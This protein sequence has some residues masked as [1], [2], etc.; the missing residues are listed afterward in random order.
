MLETG[1]ADGTHS[2]DVAGCM[3]QPHHGT[4]TYPTFPEN[5]TEDPGNT[6]ISTTRDSGEGDRHLQGA[7]SY[8]PAPRED[9]DWLYTTGQYSMAYNIPRT[10]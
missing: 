6:E 10:F 1:T 5:N 8:I 9:Y 4:L 7:A 2:A 3:T